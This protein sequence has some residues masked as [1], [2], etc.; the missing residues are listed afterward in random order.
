MKVERMMQ[1]NREQDTD[2]IGDLNSLL[3]T[4]EDIALQDCEV[5]GNKP[6]VVA[7]LLVVLRV[8]DVLQGKV[9]HNVSV[10]PA[11]YE[12][13]KKE[14]EQSLIECIHSAYAGMRG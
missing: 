14:N 13:Q 10:L 3:V 11:K 4:S 1:S 7:E 6:K 9:E 8:R 5:L 12:K 2:R